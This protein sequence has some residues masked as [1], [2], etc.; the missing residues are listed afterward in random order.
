MESLRKTFKQFQDLFDGMAPSQRLTLIAVPLLVLGGLAVVMYVGVGPAEEHLLV[1]KVFSAEEMRHAEEALRQAGLTQFRADGQK[2]LVPK[3]EVT[4]YNAALVANKGLPAQ[5]GAELERMH[6]KYSL[7]SSEKQR[8]E[9]LELAKQKELSKWI[10]TIPDI[11]D[12]GVIWERSK[13][14][15]FGGE[16]K[17]TATV[18]VRPRVGRDLTSDLGQSLRLAVAGA[19]ADLK[20]SD[21][22]VFNLATGKAVHAPAEND[23][24]SSQFVDQVNMFREMH[25][26]NIFEALSYIPNVLVAVNVDLDNLKTSWEQV[27]RL[28]KDPFATK[29]IEQTDSDSATEKRPSAQPGVISNQPRNLQQTAAPETTRNTTK[30]INSAENVPQTTTVTDKTFVGLLPKTVQVTV[31]IPKDY[32]RAV[33]IKQGE[34]ETDKAAFQTRVQQIE[35]ETKKEVSAIVTKLIPAGSAVDA[36]NVSSFV[37]LDPAGPS[38]EPPITAE[39]GEQA[40]RWG[41]TVGLGLFALWTLWMLNRSIKKLPQDD[42]STETVVKSVAREELEEEEPPPPAEPTKRDRLQD[43]VRDNPE[44]A[45]NVIKRWIAPGK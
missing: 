18:S 13:Q 40:A 23:P 32:Y 16:S 14:R 7:F 31:S 42:A 37:K 5:F 9:L 41:G 19:V 30:N 17:V 24:F 39:I 21:V 4:R 35:A 27:R 8:H 6:E 22:T 12:A 38:A 3:S 43:L 1:G 29:T 44:M 33:A 34:S 15:T 2:L 36:I 26:R 25:Q 20:A 11:E 45:A 10:R 28:G